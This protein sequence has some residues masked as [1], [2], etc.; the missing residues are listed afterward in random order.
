MKVKYIFNI[1]LSEMLHESI[2][3]KRHYL[4]SGMAGVGF[5][6]IPQILFCLNTPPTSPTI[7]PNWRQIGCNSGVLC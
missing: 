5:F 1:Y 6:F 3:F 4:Q 2:L 7:Q